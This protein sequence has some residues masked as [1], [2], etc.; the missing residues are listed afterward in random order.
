ME[1]DNAPCH[2]LQQMAHELAHERNSD[3][4]ER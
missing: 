1:Q 3:E 4:T 2:F